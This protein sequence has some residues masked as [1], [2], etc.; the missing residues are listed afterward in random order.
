MCSTSLISIMIEMQ[1][2]ARINYHFT[3]NT[4]TKIKKIHNIKCHQEH[5]ATEVL[6]LLI[7]IRSSIMTLENREQ[8]SHKI[9]HTATL[10][11]AVP[12]QNLYSGET[13]TY[14][15]KKTYI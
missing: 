14:I 9:K 4:M 5:G 15:Y 7:E 3:T 12:L 10:K 8:V 2:K 6:M 11:T 13:K 1:I